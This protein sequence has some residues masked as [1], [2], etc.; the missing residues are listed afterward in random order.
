MPQHALA[1]RFERSRERLRTVAFRILGSRAEADDAVQEAWLRLSRSP[2]DDVRNLEGWLTTVV[3]RVCLDALRVR[4]A[5]REALL[6]ERRPASDD[7]QAEATAADETGLAMM[8]VLDTLAPAERVAFVLH[9]V[10]D[11]PFDD[12]AAIVDRTPEA[13]RQLASRGRRRVKGADAPEPDPNRQRILVDAFRRAS[14]EGDLQGLLAVLAPDIVVRADA[15]AVGFGA[16]TEMR[17][18]ETVAESFLGRA[19]AAKRTTV[20][21]APSMAWIVAGQTRVVFRFGFED[22]RI[23]TLDLVADPEVVAVMNVQVLT[24]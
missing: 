5:R 2:T 14:R 10:F 21:G 1:D 12:V 3:G 18:A 15:T 11:V 22:G 4:T 13:A 23:A 7:P 8:L 17:G 6:D 19:T 20:D 16:P 9:D 24:A